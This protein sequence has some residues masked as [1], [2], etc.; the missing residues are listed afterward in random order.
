MFHSDLQGKVALITGVSSGIGKALALA[1]YRAG[2]RIAGCALDGEGLETLRKDLGGSYLA[3]VDITDQTAFQDFFGVATDRLGLAEIVIANAGVTDRKHRSIADLPIDVWRAIIETNLTGTFITLKTVL[4]ELAHARRGNIAVITSLLGQKGYAA[5]N[6]SA[7][8]ASKFGIEGLVEVA[9]A[10]FSRPFGL[11]INTVIPAAKVDTGF[12]SHLTEDARSELAPP[13][14]LNEL[15]LYL[16]ALPPFSLSGHQL[17][18]K[19]WVTDASYR[20][21]IART[22]SN[23]RKADDV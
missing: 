5:A 21:E 19:R 4:P 7:Y 2:A 15:V 12:F 17:N 20:D 18:G 8:C 16:S 9:A 3:E 23:N 1:L 22:I 11:N 10:E 6:D 14:I 13:E